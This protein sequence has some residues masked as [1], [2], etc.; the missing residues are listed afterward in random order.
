MLSSVDSTWRA[1]RLLAAQRGS[2]HSSVGLTRVPSRLS[3]S[4]KLSIILC[5]GFLALASNNC[6]H[7]R[8][9]D[10]A[11]ERSTR[12]AAHDL[13]RDEAMGGHTLS[14]H[15]GK[16]DDFLRQRLQAEPDIAA[17]STYT[18]ERTA[19]EAVAAALDEN[20]A[21][22]NSWLNREGRKSNL[23]L[24]Y[25]S[26]HVLGRCL[27]RGDSAPRDCYDAIVVLQSDGDHEFHVLTSYPDPR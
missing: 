2:P 6:N 17:A 27:R 13:R 23:V 7:S 1:A 25:H 10:A 22:L 11:Q 26:N 15:A 18:D 8:S 4:R 21:R 14:R 9:S 24:H 19:D 16:S 20:S 12:Q 3:R 5:A